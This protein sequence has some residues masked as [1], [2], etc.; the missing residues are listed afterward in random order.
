VSIT[1]VEEIGTSVVG[2]LSQELTTREARTGAAIWRRHDELETGAGPP[3]DISFE[4]AAEQPDTV[5]YLRGLQL[6]GW[7]SNPQPT[8]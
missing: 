8:D 3:R 4:A 2:K 1:H 5:L 7:D 6:R